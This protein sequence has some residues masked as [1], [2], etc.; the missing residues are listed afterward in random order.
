M[1][2]AGP[3]SG[4][5]IPQPPDA[6]PQIPAST[7]VAI[8]RLRIFGPG[9]FNIALTTAAKA[10]ASLTTPPKATTADVLQI[11]FK[12]DLHVSPTCPSNLLGS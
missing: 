5:A 6:E 11:A 1:T 4:D 10:G 9:I 3:N 7:V 8:A 12:E 2:N